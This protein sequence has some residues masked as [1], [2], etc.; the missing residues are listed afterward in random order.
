MAVELSKAGGWR[1]EQKYWIRFIIYGEASDVLYIMIIFLLGVFI[2]IPLWIKFYKKVGEDNRK[3]MIYTSIGCIIMTTILTFITNLTG[4][5]IVIFLWGIVVGGFWIIYIPTYSDVI[6]ESI[7]IT[8]TRQEGFYS[9]LRRFM[10]NLASVI[11]ALLFA[12][13]HETTGFVEVADKQTSSAN[14]GILLLFGVIPAVIMTIGLII[15]WKLYD[16]T[17][18]RSKEIRVKLEELKI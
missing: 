7:S 9:G 4:L 2:G 5:Y 10:S 11:Y 12:I 18:D 3:T 14:F 1:A 13:V 17:P 6:D 8:G 15:F 16:I